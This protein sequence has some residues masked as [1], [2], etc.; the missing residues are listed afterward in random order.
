MNI[1]PQQLGI[2]FGSGGIIGVII[3]FTAK[4]MAKVIAVI[5]GMELV[6][7]RLLESRGIIQVN[8]V[9]IEGYFSGIGEMATTSTPPTW[10]VSLLST[11]P[12]GAGFIGGFFLGFKK[13]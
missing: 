6:L 5:I 9:G 7:F 13:G 11:L 1:D 10:M 12:I 2:E 8:W 4:K 3:G